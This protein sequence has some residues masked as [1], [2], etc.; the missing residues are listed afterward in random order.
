[1]LSVGGKGIQARRLPRPTHLS[2]FLFLVLVRSLGPLLLLDFSL[3][4]VLLSTPPSLLLLFLRPSSL[5]GR[6][7]CSRR[8]FLLRL[9]QERRLGTQSCRRGRSSRSSLATG[10]LPPSLPPTPPPP[11]PPPPPPLPPTHVLRLPRSCRARP[12]RHTQSP[13]PEG[14]EAGR[15]GGKEREKR[16]QE[17]M[18]ATETQARAFKSESARAYPL[19]Q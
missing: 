12:G 6:R 19:V 17:T 7:G 18:S 1:M 11:P 9:E 14:G 10:S 4:Y 16:I 13:F 3:C 15:G 5:T 2:L 8:P